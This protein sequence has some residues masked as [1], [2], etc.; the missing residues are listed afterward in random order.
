MTSG[1]A[2]FR[3]RIGPPAPRS[4][5]PDLGFEKSIRGKPRPKIGLADLGFEK[6]IR[7][8][9]RPKIGLARS[10]F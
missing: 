5:F 3:R 7:G 8:K 4:G 9:P 6:S 1:R 2:G 10:W